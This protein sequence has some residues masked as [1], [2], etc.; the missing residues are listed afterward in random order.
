MKIFYNI[1]LYSNDIIIIIILLSRV[2]VYTKYI[3]KRYRKNSKLNL[4]KIFFIIKLINY[5]IVISTK[6]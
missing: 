4:I 5:V 2:I 3:R 6:L 1:D